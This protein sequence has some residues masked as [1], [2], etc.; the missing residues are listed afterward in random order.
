MLEINDPFTNFKL[1]L[2]QMR[3]PFLTRKLQSSSSIGSN[4]NVLIAGRR[5]IPPLQGFLRSVQTLCRISVPGNSFQQGENVA[6]DFLSQ[7]KIIP[8]AEPP[9]LRDVELLYQFFD[10]SKKLVVLTGAGISTECGIPDYRSPNGAY[11][12]GFKPITH[13]EFLRSIRARR[14]YW[15]RSYAGWRRF[16]AA[17]PGAAHIAL[18]SLE[19]A[20]RINFMITQ[21]VDR[22]HHRAG[23]N[24]LEL[25]G[26]VY[27]VVCLDCGFSF[28]RNLFQNQVKALNPK[29]AAAI[30]SLECGGIP[31]SDKSFGMKQRPDG[32]VEID[33]KFWE[34]DF[35]IPTCQKCNGVLK[36]DVIFFGDN[37]PKERAD[38]SIEAAKEC[39]AFLVLGSSVMTMSAYRLVRAAHEAGAATTIVNVGETRA[40]DFVPLKIN[41]RLG[42][43]L[44]RV[45]HF[46]S[47]S[48]P[49]VH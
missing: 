45:L 19:K 23:S 10:N 15:A 47:L 49:H 28:S 9:S 17:Q 37:V 40:D 6:S 38:M 35:H 13:Q 14:R 44:P 43:I 1:P 3:M 20:G 25:H 29:W 41:A 21:N 31:G 48:I 30:E 11:S 42:E 5:V 4:W 39:D 34:E 7:K 46:G 16:T 12:S 8:D 18:A 24:P 36:P 26:T 33:E 22:L 32:D 2:L 27:S